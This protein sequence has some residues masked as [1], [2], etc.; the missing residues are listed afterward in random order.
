MRVHVSVHTRVCVCAYVHAYM[1]VCV[2]TSARVCVDLST[3]SP[4]SLSV[5]CIVRPCVWQCTLYMYL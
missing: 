1:R 3:R 5:L 4:I 2:C